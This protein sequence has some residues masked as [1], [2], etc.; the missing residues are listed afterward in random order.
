MVLSDLQEQVLLRQERVLGNTHPPS[1]LFRPVA[2]L[3]SYTITL[4]TSACATKGE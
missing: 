1:D 2:L 4:Y 3:C